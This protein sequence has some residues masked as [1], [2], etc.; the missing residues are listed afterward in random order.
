MPVR[1]GVEEPVAAF[2]KQ[3]VPQAADLGG[4][5]ADAAIGR[6]AGRVDAGA[7]EIR[8]VFA[9][10]I[11]SLMSGHA[12]EADGDGRTGIVEIAEVFDVKAAIAVRIKDAGALDMRRDVVAI[13]REVRLQP[14]DAGN[15]L[16]NV[17]GGPQAR[18]RG[19]QDLVLPDATF[20]R[21]RSASLSATVGVAT[22]EAIFEF[23]QGAG[24]VVGIDSAYGDGVAPVL[25]FLG[26]EGRHAGMLMT[27]DV[28]LK[29]SIEHRLLQLPRQAGHF[30]EG[31]LLN[32]LPAPHGAVR[33]TIWRARCI[34]DGVAL[35]PRDAYG[36]FP[37]R[38]VGRTRTEVEGRIVE[39]TITDTRAAV[40]RRSHPFQAKVVD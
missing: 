27:R 40:I 35:Q 38:A 14:L 13:Q 18:A 15:G 5:D 12:L 9:A 32:H 2:A 1:L 31:V 21:T 20:G 16:I 8:L 24:V 23:R 6:H 28:R 26:G 7:A 4:I 34:G 29:S 39:A 10:R 25:R 19:I 11:G 33:R 3:R 37:K 30:G 22:V 36:R 17:V